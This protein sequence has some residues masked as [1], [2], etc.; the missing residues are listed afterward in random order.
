MTE[1][2]ESAELWYSGLI[3][4]IIL[5]LASGFFSG[6]ETS[7]FYLSHDEIRTL[8]V[9]KPR[10]RLVAV[11]L[12]N[13]DRLL[14]AILFWNLVI[15]LLYF[16]VSI[17]I[18]QRLTSKELNVA[19]GVFG[20]LSLFGL[21]LF[22]EVLPKSIAVFARR[23]VATTASWPLAAAVRVLDPI[24]PALSWV[25]RLV[26]RTLWPTVEREPVLHPEDLERAV[27]AFQLSEE[28]VKIEQQ[29]L[30]NILD[31]S[32]IKV[33]EIMRPR[34]TYETLTGPL[35]LDKLK[36]ITP[37]GDF[38]LVQ[39]EK[40]KGEANAVF[41]LQNFT[42][43]NGK[44]RELTLDELVY[45][46][47]CAD[48]ATALQMLQQRYTAV[49]AVVNEYGETIGVVTQE[50]LLDTILMPQPSR[51]RRLLRRDPILEI[52]PGKYHV[53][54]LTTLRHFCARFDIEFQNSQDGQ[55]TIT[56][57]LSEQLDRLPKLGDHVSW[58][59]F[60]FKV[61]HVSKVGQYRLLVSRQ[62]IP[63]EF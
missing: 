31:L 16:A 51:T 60:D 49:A 46:P 34:G 35:E 55:L 40:E 36:S 43:L 53:E 57:M 45:V 18:T 23:K 42:N 38:I 32:E 19:A 37:E 41:S 24:I 56:G 21:I 3:A 17:V 54:G 5:I 59:G 20:I 8:R 27:D 25:T 58:Q 13:P 62:P 47:W 9:G 48:L 22:G 10:E 1:F 2:I 6:S 7:F 30:H 12:S 33:E 14:T 15:N 61:V 26:R 52:G 29:V 39:N 63:S 11:L 50:D 28:I 4:M 44:E